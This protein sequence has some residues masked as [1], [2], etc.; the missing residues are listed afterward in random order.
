[1]VE[2]KKNGVE[3]FLRFFFLMHS[4]RNTH[5]IFRIIFECI[6]K[7]KFLLQFKVGIKI[8]TNLNHC[9]F[10]DNDFLLKNRRSLEVQNLAL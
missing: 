10:E 7:R 3:V 6:L 2:K 1:M 9:N 8:R 5:E 4:L